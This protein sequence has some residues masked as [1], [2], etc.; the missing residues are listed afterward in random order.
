[1]D[2]QRNHL[3]LD[4]DDGRALNRLV[5]EA[6]RGPQVPPPHRAISSAAN[7][8]RAPDGEGCHGVFHARI[9]PLL[10]PGNIR[11]SG[12]K[13]EAESAARCAGRVVDTPPSCRGL[14]DLAIPLVRALAL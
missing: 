6:V 1:M 2:L 9:T 8:T 14:S 7:E 12:K 13:V 11:N 5:F 10:C 3:T 4:F